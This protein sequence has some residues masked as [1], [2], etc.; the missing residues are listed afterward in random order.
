[1]GHMNRMSYDIIIL[2]PMEPGADDLTNVD[3]VLET[4]TKRRSSDL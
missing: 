1:M 2:K 3:E 4:G